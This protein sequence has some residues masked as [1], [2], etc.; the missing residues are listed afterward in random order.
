MPERVEAT[1]PL[2]QVKLPELVV[3]SLDVPAA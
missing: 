3:E 2:S 1:I